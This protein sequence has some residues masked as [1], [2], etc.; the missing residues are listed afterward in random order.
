[1]M[2]VLVDHI[3]SLVSHYELVNCANVCRLSIAVS[4]RK[5]YDNCRFD[6]GSSCAGPTN[7]EECL[8]LSERVTYLHI[9]VPTKTHLY[10]TRIHEF[11]M[12]MLT[13]LFSFPFSQA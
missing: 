4:F 8:H 2:A 7:Y 9:A 13:A 5:C 3:S 11:K 1:M 10:A 6:I 12:V